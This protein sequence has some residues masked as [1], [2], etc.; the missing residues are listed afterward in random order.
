MPFT[1]SH[2]AAV[3][4]LLRTGLVPSALVIGSMIPDL[5]YYAPVPVAW[6]ATH[7]AAG[8]VGVD[9][10]LGVAVFALWHLLLVPAAVAVA[11]GGLRDRLGP[12]LPVP[13]RLH[14]RSVG[15]ALLVLVSL[16]V[17][18]ATHV[19]WDAFTHADRWGTGHIAWLEASHG[20]LPGYRWMQYAGG[21][22]GAVV[23]LVSVARWWIRTQAIP[24][25]QRVPALGPRHALACVAVVGGCLALGGLA[26][27]LSGVSGGGLRAGAFLA[28]TWGGGLGAAGALVCAV[29]C[30]PRLRSGVGDAG[31]P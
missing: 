15:S 8:V 3:V 20:P 13:P 23:L 6:T 26:G 24:G 9:V 2:P 30:A 17:G 14:V 21:A 29:A 11:P 25:A 1:G 22:L 5:P 19:V 4:P 18:A 7:S 28:A 31:A 10:A 16:L 12:D 27:L